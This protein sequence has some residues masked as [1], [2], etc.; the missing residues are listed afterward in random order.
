[1]VSVW[2]EHDCA[3][4]EVPAEAKTHAPSDPQ[5][6][7]WQIVV[8]RNGQPAHSSIAGFSDV[9]AG[10]PWTDDTLV[11]TLTEE[12]GRITGYG[13]RVTDSVISRA[14]ERVEFT[15]DPVSTSLRQSAEA[16]H[17]VGFLKTPPDLTGIYSLGL[18]NEVLQEKNLPAVAK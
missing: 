1:L 8:S 11:R 3:R 2:S 12:Y 15:W 16:A 14:M 10:I 6:A 5:L 4:Q 9:D 18:L 13:G 17:K 7:G